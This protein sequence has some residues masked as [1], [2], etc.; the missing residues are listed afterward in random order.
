[1]LL[2]KLAIF[3]WTK[4]VAAKLMVK[5]NRNHRLTTQ[6]RNKLLIFEFDWKTL[7]VEK[8]GGFSKRKSKEEVKQD[9][10]K[11][12]NL[13][14][15]CIQKNQS[16]LESGQ[17][18]APS[19]SVADE[20]RVRAIVDATEDD[21]AANSATTTPASFNRKNSSGSTSSSDSFIDLNLEDPNL[22]K[23]RASGILRK[24]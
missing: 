17:K 21:D 19:Q 11:K 3:L 1:M 7:K 23:I 12:M 9:L 6:N 5:I 16:V 4:N 15:D 24:F 13:C 18:R 8:S 20:E 22:T 2:V 10:I 14:V